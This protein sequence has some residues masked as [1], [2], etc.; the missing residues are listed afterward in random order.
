LRRRRWRWAKIGRNIGFS[1]APGSGNRGSQAIRSVTRQ[2][3]VAERLDRALVLPGAL[4]EH[5]RV[6]EEAAPAL[7]PHQGEVVVVDRHQAEEQDPAAADAFAGRHLIDVEGLDPARHRHPHDRHQLAV[8]P[9]DRG[10]ALPDRLRFSFDHR[11]GGYLGA[12]VHSISRRRAGSAG[13][14]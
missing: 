11:R 8:D 9:L 1:N 2:V 13:T 4:G 10:D 14:R 3:S 12:P 7:D 6:L 5:R